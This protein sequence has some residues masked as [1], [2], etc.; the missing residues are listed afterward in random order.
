MNPITPLSI[1]LL[2]VTEMK[3]HKRNTE[4]HQSVAK[5]M[6]DDKNEK[7]VESEE[8]VQPDK[9]EQGEVSPLINATQGIVTS[10][11]SFGDIQNLRKYDNML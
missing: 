1:D 11:L 8:L 3:A 9:T 6:S 10:H 7:L 5:S 2:K 4:S